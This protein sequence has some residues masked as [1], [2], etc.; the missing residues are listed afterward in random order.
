MTLGWD[1]R[2]RVQF[3]GDAHVQ[4]DVCGFNGPNAW[5]IDGA[6]TVLEPLGLPA[7]SDPQWLAQHLNTALG[8]GTQEDGVRSVLAG[9]LT[10]IDQLA[11]PL[12]GSERVR[13]PSAAISVAQLNAAGV[14]VASL[15]D[16]TVVVKTH[17]GAAHVVRATHADA[18]VDAVSAAQDSGETRRKLL[19]RD[20]EL[21]NT[22]GRLWVARREAEAAHHAVVVQLGRP[23]LMV[24]A[25]DGAWRAVELGIVSG[26][27]EFLA[28]TAT[29][30]GALGLM[31]DLRLLQ[32]QIGEVSDDATVLTLA[33]QQQSG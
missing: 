13:F 28:R 6:T 22:P 3:E 33:P 14:E 27:E 5:I 7:A 21:R 17:D 26:P 12:V 24:L 9:A 31:H 8:E 2:A 1:I 19:R 30:L 10:T 23:E 20:R 16:C 15:A 29:T 32:E 25:S 18:G 11:A 4:E